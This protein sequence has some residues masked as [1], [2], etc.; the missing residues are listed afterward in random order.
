LTK[1]AVKRYKV[2][3]YVESCNSQH[4]YK[5]HDNDFDL[6]N[7]TWLKMNGICVFKEGVW[8]TVV[9]TISKKDAEKELGKKILN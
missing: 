8:A 1:E 2:G 3:D 9:E 5:I 6:P 7:N 4:I